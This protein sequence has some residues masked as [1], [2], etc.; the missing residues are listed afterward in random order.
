MNWKEVKEFLLIGAL[1]ISIAGI[2][3]L[4]VYGLMF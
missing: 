4:I 3:A 1:A 2:T